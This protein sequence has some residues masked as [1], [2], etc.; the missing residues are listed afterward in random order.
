MDGTL[1]IFQKQ[2]PLGQ[3]ITLSGD[4]ESGWFTK[5]MVDAIMAI[6]GTMNNPIIFDYKTAQT[7]D[8]PITVMFDWSSGTPVVFNPIQPKENII[9]TDWFTGEINLIRT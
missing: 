9:G 7:G 4:I 2:Y 8:S 3:S 6:V 1:V 5:S